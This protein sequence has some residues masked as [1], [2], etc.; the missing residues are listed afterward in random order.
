MVVRKAGGLVAGVRFSPARKNMKL[1]IWD[2]HGTL[3]KGNERGVIGLSNEALKQRGYAERFSTEHIGQL[4][5]KKWYEYFAHILPYESPE[6]HLQLQKDCVAMH[7]KNSDIIASHIAPN[8][9]ASAVLAAIGAQH[10]QILISNTPPAHVAEFLDMVG[11]RPFFPEGKYFGTDSHHP[12]AKTSKQDIAEA[13]MTDKRFEEI[14]AIG[15]SPQDMIPLPQTT[16][17]LYAH[18]GLPFRECTATYRI[19]DLWEVLREL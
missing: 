11:L 9:H 17:Y 1:F 3:E 6:M 10:D 13:Y 2:F 14:I 4:Y 15:D 19:R 7:V 18:E 16:H 12:D 5:G 8:D